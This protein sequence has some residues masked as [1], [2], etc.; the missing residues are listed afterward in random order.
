MKSNIK[1][2]SEAS[3]YQA[4]REESQPSSK[5]SK[6]LQWAAFGGKRQQNVTVKVIYLE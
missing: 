1:E 5:R 6:G 2:P 3:K 4:K